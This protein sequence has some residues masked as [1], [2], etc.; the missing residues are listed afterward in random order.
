MTR[1]RRQSNNK[2]VAFTE[3]NLVERILKVLARHYPRALSNKEI[4]N[5]VITDQNKVN[6]TLSRLAVEMRI[7]K[8]SRGKYTRKTTELDIDLDYSQTVFHNLLIHSKCCNEVIGILPQ[9]LATSTKE[10]KRWKLKFWGHD[11]TIMLHKSKLM[12]IHLNCT[13]HPIDIHGLTAFRT[14]IEAIFYKYPLKK[15]ELKKIDFSIDSHRF[16]LELPKSILYTDL[17]GRMLRMYQKDKDI[18][19][20]ESTHYGKIRLETA[21]NL[22][23]RLVTPP[24]KAGHLEEIDEK[25]MEYIR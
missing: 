6:A 4:A 23:K 10:R 19:R 7:L 17:E 24:E 21:I 18:L 1:K 25:D 9:Q 14:W 15:L 8:V 12:E 20:F 22:F 5:M 11:V 3:N 16:R 2:I 13:K